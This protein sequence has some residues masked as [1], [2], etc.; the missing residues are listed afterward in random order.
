MVEV[1]VAGCRAV[2]IGL[3]ATAVSAALTIVLISSELP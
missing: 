2:D 1:L 3:I